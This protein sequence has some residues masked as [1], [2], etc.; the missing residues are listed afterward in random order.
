M[1]SPDPDGR[2]R[3]D[4]LA[5]AREIAPYYT[6][7][8]DPEADDAGG[9]LVRLF[10][11][12]A[13]EVTE[14]V[15]RVPTKHRIAFY[16]T[17]EFTQR[18]PQAAGVPLSVTVADGVDRNVAIPAGTQAVGGS[19][20]QTFTVLAGDGFEATP[21]RLQSVYSVAPDEG[22]IYDHNQLLAGQQETLFLGTEGRQK[23]ALHIGHAGQLDV[24][25]ST[26]DPRTIRVTVETGI[27]GP[28]LANRL[29]WDFYGKRGNA[30]GWHEVHTVS[31][32]DGDDA[33]LSHRGPPYEL[34]MG[35]VVTGL[36]IVVSRAAEELEPEV[37]ETLVDDLATAVVALRE[38]LTGQGVQ[39]AIKRL[40]DAVGTLVQSLADGPVGDAVDGEFQAALE[41]LA[42]VLDSGPFEE[43]L[44]TEVGPAMARVGEA[45]AD[46]PANRAISRD[47]TPALEELSRLI[48]EEVD[49]ESLEEELSQT[50]EALR[51]GDATDELLT[52]L[53][54]AFASVSEKFDQPVKLPGGGPEAREQ[55]PVPALSKA[56]ATALDGLRRELSGAALPAVLRALA[57]VIDRLAAAIRDETLDEA[58]ADVDAALAVIED[59][60]QAA[61]FDD[62]VDEGRDSL[63]TEVKALLEGPVGDVIRETAWPALAEL[64]GAL[65]EDPAVRG[66][67]TALLELATA[68]ITGR[69]GAAVREKLGGAIAN[70]ADAVEETDIDRN[71]EPLEATLAA[72]ADALSDTQSAQM[73]AVDSL[74][75]SFTG[76]LDA[77]TGEEEGTGP[78]TTRTVELSIDGTPTETAV[79]GTESR[80]L[81]CVVPEPEWGSDLFDMRIGRSP[82]SGE[83]TPPVELG[84]VPEG[85]V[86]TD[87]LLSNGTE[88]STDDGGCYPLGREPRQQDAFYIAASEAFTKAGAS[89][90]ITLGKV[91]DATVGFPIDPDVAWEYW[92][93]DAWS[94][95]ELQRPSSERVGTFRESGSIEFQVPGD[96]AQRSVFGHDGHWVRAR[97]DGGSY[98]RYEASEETGSSTTNSDEEYW[99][100]EHEVAPPK[101]DSVEV[102]YTGEGALQPAR[103]LVSL[104]NLAYSPASLTEGRS[105]F[106]PFAGLPDAEQ[107]LYLGFDR[108]LTDGPV[109]LLFDFDEAQYTPD[110]HPRIRWERQ[111]S[112][113]NWASVDARDGTEGL[114]ERGLVSL[115]FGQAT[116]ETSRF[117]RQRHWLRARVTGTP[118]TG[119][120][121]EDTGED[122]TSERPGPQP[123]GNRVP[124]EPPAGEPGRE[125]PTVVGV[126]PNSGMAHNV[127]A[128]EGELL[129]SSDGTQ[130][131]TVSVANR[132]ATDL[133]LWVDENTALSEGQRE[134]LS[135]SPAVETEAETGSDGAVT[136]FWVRWT[137][138]DS[139]R[140]SDGN[141]RHY[142]LD[143]R[144][145]EI[146]FGDGHRGRIPPQGR[147]NVRAN[148]RTGGGS[149]GNVPAGAISEL[150]SSIAFV[151]AVTNP[152]PA[153]GGADAESVDG[154]LD[155]AP[156]ELRD[157]G[158]AVT[159]ADIERIALDASRKL[160][161]AHCLRGMDRAGDSAPGWV[162]L[163]VVPGTADD[164]PVP[165]V[166]LRE[167]V[168]TAV[169]ER[170]PATLVGDPNQLVVRGPSY[171][172]VSVEATLAAVGVGSLARLEETARA[173]LEAFLHPLTGGPEGSGWPFGEAPCLSDFYTLLE[174][175]DGVDHVGEVVLRFHGSDATVTIRDEDSI[176]SMAAD[177]LVHGGAHELRAT[178]VDRTGGA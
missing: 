3:D 2:R 83:P 72:V 169:S 10:A 60:L 45:F 142:M 160:A 155:R 27:P 141:D 86:P 144:S 54:A 53:E 167:Q 88:L 101:L 90:E 26:E 163:V 17:L 82:T 106:Q 114:T 107:T 143:P 174:N 138:V 134:A 100:T 41:R 77:E 63:E 129:G 71:L 28:D 15:D 32:P 136:Q 96:L 161:K 35:K 47:A 108:P 20:E 119:P 64:V 12:L 158:R 29:D 113:S 78:V 109:S 9:A 123:C 177:V 85:T 37:L 68:L 162:T 170:A 126:Y 120:A 165:S 151:D 132:P 50:E 44:L 127:R 75:R 148:Y 23:H 39:E 173:E 112:D 22:Q 62:S 111:R 139:L 38:G 157:R 92:D 104:N 48:K 11:E 31:T 171:V 130:D 94:R 56:I 115:T 175:V 65:G 145:G 131:Q 24:E 89:V 91:T 70:L 34:L 43:A 121:S 116:I 4:L 7:E 33:G 13:E 95:L 73:D 98:G 93:G 14:R 46:G 103:N 147:D 140:R 8:W 74:H 25:G 135:E 168:R 79:D 137:A 156:K 61:G 30:E 42:E 16:D 159:P 149:D 117:G 52:A 154:A 87:T 51:E 84:P 80:W 21:A 1:G 49:T 164:K 133:D 124:T 125:R 153:D 118:F 67:G 5:H 178:R 97:L 150:K 66:A 40:R 69:A 176:P 19:P 76:Y 55:A 105:R 59:A 81:R 166:S 57:T 172:A 6:D 36:A 122:G 18:P 102:R 110:I 99:V 146:T 58:L 128:V 152:L